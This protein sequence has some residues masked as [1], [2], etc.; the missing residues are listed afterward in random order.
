MDKENF[1]IRFYAHRYWNFDE[2]PPVT[3]RAL[4]AKYIIDHPDE[5]K[6]AGP[7]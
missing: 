5:F 6:G 1:K 3:Y 4:V 7:Q 2:L